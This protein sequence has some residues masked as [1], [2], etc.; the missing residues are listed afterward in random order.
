MEI[1]NLRR[2]RGRSGHRAAGRQCRTTTRRERG[3]RGAKGEAQRGRTRQRPRSRPQRPSVRRDWSSATGAKGPVRQSA[4]ELVAEVWA[5][6]PLLQFYGGEA[7]A[8][9]RSQTRSAGWFC[10]QR[11]GETPLWEVDGHENPIAR[12]MSLADPRLHSGKADK[13]RTG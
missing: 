7:R 5:G 9:G 3:R 10:E 4:P 1:L 11:I 6:R 12:R 13:N 8:V 2:P